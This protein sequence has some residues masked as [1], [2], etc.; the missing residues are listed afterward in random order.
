MVFETEKRNY[1]WK[2]RRFPVSANV[3]GSVFEELEARDGEVTARNFLDYSR[4]KDA[5]THRMFEWND[6]KAAE[7]YRLHQARVAINA[8]EVEV[9]LVESEPPETVTAFLNVSH[10][11]R[12]GSARYVNAICALSDEENRNAVLKR[13][14]AELESFRRK[15]AKLSELSAVLAAIDETLGGE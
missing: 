9:T 12:D 3:V 11:N 1:M 15:Y 8:L 14:C 13:A 4:P 6:A 10:T 7:S 2:G 5:V